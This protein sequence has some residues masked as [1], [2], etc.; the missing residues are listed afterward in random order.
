V[1]GSKLSEILCMASSRGG[2][3]RDPIKPPTLLA[4]RGT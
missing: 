3:V 1:A 2:L 4:S